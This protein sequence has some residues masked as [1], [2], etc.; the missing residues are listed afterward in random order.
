MVASW[1]E[2]LSAGRLGVFCALGAAAAAGL[3]AL[4]LG[5]AAPTRPTRPKASAPVVTLRVATHYNAPQRAPL[6]A[7][8]RRYEALHPSVRIVHQQVSYEDFFQTVMIS[9]AGRA[10]VDIYNL[11]SI[12]SPQLIGTGALDPPPADIERFVRARYTPATIGAATVRGRLWGI[13]AA[14]SA[15]QLVWNKRLFAAAGIAGPPRTWAELTR[16]AAAIT[17]T[18]RQGN[19]LVGGYAFG[20]QVSDVVHTF[21]AMM[22]AAGTP[23]YTADLRGTNLRSPAALRLLTQ[24]TELFRRRITSNTVGSLQFAQGAV[25]MAVIANW[26]KNT[27]QTALGD[28][29]ASTVGVAPIPTDGPGGTMIYSFFWGVDS[30]SPAKREAWNLL[31]WLN[32]P[33][34]DGLSC[35]G[36]MLADIGDLTGNT[37]DLRAMRA[38]IADPFSRQFV[39]ALNAPGAAS[40]PNLWHAEEVDRLL[41]YYIELAWT[42]RMTPA[43]ALAQ[44]DA[45]IRDILAEQPR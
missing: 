34:G 8:F 40:Q 15:Y 32:T 10:P 13:P 16:D 33:R 28:R 14:V 19:I 26:Q 30:A 27:L 23:P 18:N 6:T 7:C 1:G 38:R 2:S 41:K 37:A 44:A 35:V 17:R 36:A 11:Y 24:Q 43:A 3:T 4:A 21:Y 42:G 12:W 22:Y 45:R 39:A 9:R 25:G 29:F 20:P 5:G 31:R